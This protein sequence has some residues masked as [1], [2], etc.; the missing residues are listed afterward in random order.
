M[1]LDSITIK[2]DEWYTPREAVEP[3]IKYL[4][5]NSTI[6]CP[7][8]KK[9]SEFVK[10][11]NEN[12]FKVMYSHIDLGQDFFKMNFD[13]SSVDYI[14]SNPP[15]SKKTE[16]LEHLYQLNKP[17]MM[18]IGCVGIFESQKRFEMFKQNGVEVLIF[19][20]RVKFI[21]DDGNFT[22]PPFSSWYICKGIFKDK[23]NFEYLGGKK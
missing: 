9:E 20:K 8:D 1:K 6:W 23:I 11:F 18:L 16:V 13:L 5:P 10:V 12:G 22:A 15:Y 21:K 3:I 17:F 4:K 14:I 19:N 2:D 7:F